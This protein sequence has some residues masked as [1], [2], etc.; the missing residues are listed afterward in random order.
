[1]SKAEEVEPVHDRVG[2]VGGIESLTVDGRRWFFGFDYR[3]D[4]VVS[5]LIDDEA[6][7]AAFASQHMRQLDGVHD[8]AYWRRLVTDSIRVS[9]LTRRPSDREFT[10]EGLAEQRRQLTPGHHLRY[11]L[12]AAAGW[13]DSFLEEAAIQSALTILGVEDRNYECLDDAV[14]ALQASDRDT[15]EAARLVVTRFLDL[16]LDQA[17]ANWPEVFS[18][19]RARQISADQGQ[20]APPA[21][22]LD[23]GPATTP[24]PGQ[25]RRDKTEAEKQEVVKELGEW[26]ARPDCRSFYFDKA[27]GD[28]TEE[29]SGS[30][31]KEE[32]YAELRGV[33]T[34]A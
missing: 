8:R 33:G 27:A 28:D 17:P 6:R 32:Y 30:Q 19:L 13:P 18:A 10:S 14:E 29:P 16:M 5:P 26:F 7:M 23:A 9:E 4:W 15:A 24:G 22:I 25:Q 21:A 1:V 31:D 34:L 2:H 12:A 3:L 20:A 11:L